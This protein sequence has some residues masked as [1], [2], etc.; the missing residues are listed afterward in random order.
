MMKAIRFAVLFA[1]LAALTVGTSIAQ[2]DMDREGWPE[3]FV[4]GLFGGDDSAEALRDNEPL[5]AYLAEALDMEVLI[6][7]GTSYSA[8]IEAMRADRVDAMAVGP[9][10]YVLA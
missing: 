10:A 4:L 7:T 5:R 3:P 9:F 1:V 6:S 2:D 8:V